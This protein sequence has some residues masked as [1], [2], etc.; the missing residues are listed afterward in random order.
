M[1]MDQD[2]PWAPRPCSGCTR[3]RP[4]PVRHRHRQ[5]DEQLPAGPALRLAGKH[6]EVHHPRPPPDPQPDAAQDVPPRLPGH[7]GI[8][9]HEEKRRL[10][11]QLFMVRS[12][13]AAQCVSIVADYPCYFYLKRTE[14][15][16]IASANP[17]PHSYYSALREILD[18]I[19]ETVEPG[20]FRD[21]LLRRFYRGEM[22]GRSA[23]CGCGRETP[24][25]AQTSSPRYADSRR[26]VPR[27]RTGRAGGAASRAG[28]PSFAR[29]AS[30]ISRTSSAASSRSR[31]GPPS[32]RC[33]GETAYSTRM[34]TQASSFPTA[35]RSS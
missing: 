21:R 9:F 26:A 24:L 1:F 33:S 34:S 8:R 17:D 35:H 20:A 3:R 22:L 28:R 27:D 12:Y 25:T 30:K 19:D 6:R 14:G 10:E 11:D 15:R 16:N 31:P 29:A 32:K 13:L 5:G 2:D 23:T 18:V 4:E 7:S